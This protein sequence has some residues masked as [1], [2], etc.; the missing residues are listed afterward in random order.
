MSRTFV[1]T[2]RD[3]WM[4]PMRVIAHFVFAFLIVSLW[5]EEAG[6]LSGCA[7]EFVAENTSY[8]ENYKKRSDD[9]TENLSCIVFILM[10][11]WFG[12]I[13]CVLL[14]YPKQMHTLLK[15]YHNGWYSI[16]SFYLANVLVDAIFQ[17]TIP[18]LVSVPAYLWTGQ[19]EEDWRFYHFLVICILLALTSSSMG[20]IVS[21][22]LMN[23]PTAA[24]FIGSNFGFVL[25]LFSG[26]DYGFDIP[27]DH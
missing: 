10:I 26:K 12:S 1:L 20:L 24:V 18:N 6:K 16:F 8:F 19:Y 7:D 27:F 9:L 21:V 13:F 11:T 14:S 15:E 22:W 23:Y 2:T 25:Y 17:I 5:G 3:I 4:L